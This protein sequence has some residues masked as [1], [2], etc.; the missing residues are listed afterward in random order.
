[1]YLVGQTLIRYSQIT[2]WFFVDKEKNDVTRDV[3]IK[4]IKKHIST[5]I[6][7]YK[8]SVKNWDAVNVAI[9]DDGSL[10]Q[11]KFYTIIKEAKD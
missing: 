5:V 4:R 11:S 2:S 9:N 8:V 6:G 3:L 10:R 7:W 1:M